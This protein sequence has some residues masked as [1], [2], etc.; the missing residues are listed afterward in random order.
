MIKR[1]TK[2]QKEK[3][4]YEIL[5]LLKEYGLNTDVRIYFAGK[6]LTGNG[7]IIS[8]VRA[9]DRFDYANDD[10]L[11][12]AFEGSFY[13]VINY[14]APATANIV[15]PKF[16]GILKAYGL[17]YE[18]GNPWNL[19]TYYCNPKLAKSVPEIKEGENAKNPVRI[20][21]DNCP[22]ELEAVRA[23][24]EQRQNI[25]GDVGTCVL[26][27]GFTFKHKGVYYKMPPQGRWQGS[28]S[29]EASKDD[30]KDMLLDIGCEDITYDWGRM[31]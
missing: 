11:S 14:Y 15:L 24:W 5:E 31:D 18:L 26:G 17:Y 8:G 23:E 3:L 20:Y 16:S 6:C 25:Y 12:M 7:D 22:A 28:L 1:L 29:W 2:K 30:I 9:S 19:A 13:E 4:A 10:T 21:R 27:A